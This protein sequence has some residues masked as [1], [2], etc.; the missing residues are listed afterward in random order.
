MGDHRH[1]YKGSA[2]V[3]IVAAVR[4]LLM[5]WHQHRGD[6]EGAVA[7]DGGEG[8]ERD[9]AAANAAALSAWEVMVGGV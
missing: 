5:P 4:M 9:D 6:G 3:G 2:G 1:W 7:R 8:G